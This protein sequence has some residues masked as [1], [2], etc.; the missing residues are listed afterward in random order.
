MEQPYTRSHSALVILQGYES[1][2]YLSTFIRNQVYQSGNMF[3]SC[4]EHQEIAP[5]MSETMKLV[6]ENL[7]NIELNDSKI[8]AF[9]KQI[10]HFPDQNN[11]SLELHAKEKSKAINLEFNVR[12]FTKHGIK[13]RGDSTKKISR[14]KT[15]LENPRKLSNINPKNNM[16]LNKCRRYSLDNDRVM[17]P[18]YNFNVSIVTEKLMKRSSQL[19]ESKIHLKSR[20]SL[21]KVRSLTYNPG[22]TKGI[23]KDT[24]NLSD[25]DFLLKRHDRTEL[26]KER[27]VS[28]TYNP[29][30]STKI[31]KD[32]RSLTNRAFL[33]ERQDGLRNT[34]LRKV[35]SASL[36]CSSS[37]STKSTR[38]A[39][40]QLV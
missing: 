34:Q 1:M 28:L 27:S 10:D 37:K 11:L 33:L 25:R 7:K 14:P 4:I 18:G 3:K 2:N 38:T 26:R 16:Q 6:V 36:T 21:E 17:L 40:V 30:K 39:E 8:S 32:N 19:T 23:L 9:S 12:T 13:A 15:S 5:P 24:T 31:D 29:S 35:R 20:N 22:K